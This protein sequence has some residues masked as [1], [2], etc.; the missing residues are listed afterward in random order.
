MSKA[1][2]GHSFEV[3]PQA[4][5]LG[6]Q[7]RDLRQQLL[8]LAFRP[9]AA[10]L[11]LH[12]AGH[13]VDPLLRL[14]RVAAAEQAREPRMRDGD[15]HAVGIIV[16]DV[17]PVHLARPQGDSTLRNQLLHAIRRELVRVWRRH[18]PHA[19]QARLE[20]HEHEA[21]ENFL[22]ER[23][24]AAALHVETVERSALRHA[25][26]LAFERVTPVVIWTGD[27]LAA[28]TLLRVEQA[29]G[30]MAAHVVEAAR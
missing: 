10:D 2:F 28:V 5:A 23:H 1:T 4:L 22:L 17:L 19:R 9:V 11:V 26:Q 18:L 16:G 25:D 24:Q 27:E 15:V 8:I 14:D 30:A 21:H 3:R 7:V 20:A 6:G 29:R 12:D 13:L